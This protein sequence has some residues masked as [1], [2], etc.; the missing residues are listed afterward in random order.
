MSASPSLR[1]LRPG[2]LLLA[3]ALALS[4]GVP[5]MAEALSLGEMRVDSKLGEPLRAEIPLLLDREEESR[6]L[7]V[8]VAA[9]AEYRQMDLA[10]PPFIGEVTVKLV[11]ETGKPGKILVQTANVV[12]DPYF[13]LLLKTE[14]GRGSHFRAYRVVLDLPARAVVEPAPVVASVVPKVANVT[15][16]GPVRPGETLLGV[17]RKVAGEGVGV[18]QALAA[19]WAANKAKFTGE[20]I[21][22]LP[23]GVELAIP[24]ADEMR[25]MS[26]TDARALVKRHAEAWS[27]RAGVNAATQPKPAPA[28]AAEGQ[29]FGMRLTVDSPPAPGSKPAAAEVTPLPASPAPPAIDPE[30]TARLEENMRQL[31]DEQEKLREANAKIVKV[32]AERDALK[33]DLSSLTRR[34]HALEQEKIAVQGEPL[35][36]KLLGGGAG[37]VGFLAGALAWL[38]R[39]RGMA[40]GVA[41][42]E[43]KTA[44]PIEERPVAPAPPAHDAGGEAG[45]GASRMGGTMAAALSAAA[46][47]AAV[48]PEQASAPAEEESDEEGVELAGPIH[49]EAAAAPRQEI[50]GGSWQPPSFPV[51]ATD[52]EESASAFE[53]LEIDDGVELPELEGA[54]SGGEPE[55]VL[56]ALETIAF[57]PDLGTNAGTSALHPEPAEPEELEL[58]DFELDEERERA[59]SPSGPV[60]TG[61]PAARGGDEIEV[62]ELSID[63]FELGKEG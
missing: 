4:G 35:D 36:W 22:G 44:P 13:Q 41:L 9:P 14:L 54:E 40:A 7:G 8:F 50:P 48:M 25:R 32:E 6:E 34:L 2:A 55:G 37:A 10:R 29:K 30:W 17:A 61:E 38:L 12:K 57:D 1:S 51:E 33:K 45:H 49:L 15:R 5:R 58:I 16:Y 56:P 23:V 47:V 19:I 53:G 21:H 60:A 42:R 28:S 3:A 59:P 27:Q 63:D 11:K 26:E 20:N 18:H 39:R 52:E 31:R 43:E 46:V 24:A 62:L